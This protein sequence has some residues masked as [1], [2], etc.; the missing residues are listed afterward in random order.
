MLFVFS[1]FPLF[2]FF[3]DCSK[4]VLQTAAS[5]SIQCQKKR[6]TYWLTHVD[7]WGNGSLASFPIDPC[8]VEL[9]QHCREGLH[10]M[11]I[12]TYT[13]HKGYSHL[14]YLGFITPQTKRSQIK[15][16]LAVTMNLYL[17]FASALTL[18]CKFIHSKYAGTELCVEYQLLKLHTKRNINTW[19][20]VEYSI[21]I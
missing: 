21:A 15:T 2:F 5:Q 19:V 14:S 4:T 9:Q 3:F 7:R 1:F 20:E 17:N 6:A 12:Q 16:T 18:F 8:W 11:A 10:V 13:I